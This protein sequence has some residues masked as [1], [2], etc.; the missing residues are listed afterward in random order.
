MFIKLL[1]CSRPEGRC[2]INRSG[3]VSYAEPKGFRYKQ[4]EHAR[5]NSYN[6]MHASLATQRKSY[7]TQKIINVCIN[8][9]IEEGTRE[10]LR[11]GVFF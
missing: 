6:G 10:V 11:K 5:N 7:Y 1:L 4:S 8:S 2:S 9:V 3:Y